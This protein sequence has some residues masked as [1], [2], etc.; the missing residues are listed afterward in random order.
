VP[1]LTGAAANRLAGGAATRFKAITKAKVAAL[2]EL[3]TAWGT[4]FSQPQ[5]KGIR[6]THSVLTGKGTTTR[7]GEYIHT[8]TS[9]SPGGACIRMDVV[10]V[11][12]RDAR[13]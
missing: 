1:G 8:P 2:D 5:A 13:V 7:G 6:A 3:H 10:P 12:L 11:Q 4:A 9:L